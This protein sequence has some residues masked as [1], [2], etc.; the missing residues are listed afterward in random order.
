MT[1]RGIRKI[2]TSVTPFARKIFGEA[3]AISKRLKFPQDDRTV[4]NFIA[5]L[6][7]HFQRSK[8]T[9]DIL[10][11]VFNVFGRKPSLGA[12]FESCLKVFLKTFKILSCTNN[13][14][15]NGSRSKDTGHRY[16]TRIVQNHLNIALMKIFQYLN[17]I[18]R[19]IFIS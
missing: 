14:L 17:G 7:M 11:S 9:L 1:E 2:L 12:P 15:S 16:P 8:S 3:L 6:R 4:T 10:K 13:W 19:H 18:Y 5:P